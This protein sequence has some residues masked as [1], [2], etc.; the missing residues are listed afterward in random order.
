MLLL[1]HMWLLAHRGFAVCGEK[2]VN[3]GPGGC[4]GLLCGHPSTLSQLAALV[5]CPSAFLPPPALPAFIQTPQG[6]RSP[7]P[8][9]APAPDLWASQ[10]CF[11]LHHQEALIRYV[12]SFCINGSSGTGLHNELRHKPILQTRSPFSQSR[13]TNELGPGL[14]KTG[15]LAQ[16]ADHGLFNELDSSLLQCEACSQPADYGI[17]SQSCHCKHLCR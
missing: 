5:G 17:C 16:P 9:P 12:E 11:P 8:A 4:R 15:M 13:A 6:K 14:V 3:V 1:Q 7:P 10:P 2:G